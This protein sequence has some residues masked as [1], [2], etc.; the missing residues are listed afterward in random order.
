MLEAVV[1]FK[2]G[3]VV[4]HMRCCTA[5]FDPYTVYFSNTTVDCRFAAVC[6]TIEYCIVG[7]ST[8]ISICICV[9][10]SQVHCLRIVS[11][12]TASM[13]SSSATAT[14][15]FIII[16][17]GYFP[18]LLGIVFFGDTFVAVLLRMVAISA[19]AAWRKGIVWSIVDFP[20]WEETLMV[21]RTSVVVL[22]SVKV[23]ISNAQS[24]STT[25]ESE[26]TC[27]FANAPF[28]IRLSTNCR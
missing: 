25:G 19:M 28:E 22:D 8:I 2:K 1:V 13:T 24:C 18:S 11:P 15:P 17:L 7:G 12:S 3:F 5:V 23:V 14:T 20:W 16:V 26:A 21:V 27:F 10:I 9:C 6:E 4:M